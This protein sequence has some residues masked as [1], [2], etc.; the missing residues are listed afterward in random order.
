M[1]H[2]P[3]YRANDVVARIVLEP[4]GGH[5]LEVETTGGIMIASY[6]AGAIQKIEAACAQF[7]AVTASADGGPDF[8]NRKIVPVEMRR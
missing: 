5:R 4:S 2:A 1:R 6:D 3:T 7:R 8:H